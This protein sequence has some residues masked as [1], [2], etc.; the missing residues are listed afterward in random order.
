MSAPLTGQTAGVAEKLQAA[1]HALQC[2]ELAAK[3][4]DLIR[5]LTMVLHASALASWAYYRR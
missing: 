2:V 3:I 1:E 4:R 5:Q